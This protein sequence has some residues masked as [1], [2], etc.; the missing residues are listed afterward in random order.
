MANYS[1]ASEVSVTPSEAINMTNDPDLIVVMAIPNV[2]K[3][4][5]DVTYW[6]KNNGVLPPWI[7]LKKAA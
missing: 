5:V 6:S 1:R 3:D 2:E 4:I 7:N